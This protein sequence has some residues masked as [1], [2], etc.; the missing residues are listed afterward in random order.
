[1][2]PREAA[3]AIFPSIARSLQK[4]LRITRQQPFHSMTS[5]LDHLTLILSHHLSPKSFLEKYLT[6][7]PVYQ[8]D[9]QRIPLQSWGLVSDTLVSRSITVG[10]HFVLT[11]GDLSLLV[12]VYGLT[13]LRLREE[14]I[15]KGKFAFRLNSETSV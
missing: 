4:Y 13:H 2:E 1:M 10:S 12:Q 8:Q 6:T 9:S 5:I 14:M 3:Q 11:Q 15:E 7:G